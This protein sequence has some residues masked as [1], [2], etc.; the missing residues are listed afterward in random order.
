MLKLCAP[1]GDLDEVA[2][3]EA[4]SGLHSALWSLVDGYVTL[5]LDGAI[6]NGASPWRNA[7]CFRSCWGSWI[8]PAQAKRAHIR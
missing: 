3:G 4:S 8:R 1:V 7:S 2:F 6:I 5:V